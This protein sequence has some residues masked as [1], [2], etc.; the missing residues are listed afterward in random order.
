MIRIA[1]VFALLFSFLAAAGARADT[2]EVGAGCTG[3]GLG[4]T[5]MTTDR[6]NIA[7]CLENDSG[8]LVWKAMSSSGPAE[9]LPGSL[10]G[11]G[12]TMKYT[13]QEDCQK[14]SCPTKTTY[15]AANISLCDGRAVSTGS[16]GAEKNNC[17]SGYGLVK[18]PLTNLDYYYSSTYGTFYNLLFCRKS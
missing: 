13:Y 17:P 16:Y 3:V 14:A 15:S 10:C 12:Y 7:A 8:E 5:T 2:V 9:Q 18:V 11:L 1:A 6:K 4:T